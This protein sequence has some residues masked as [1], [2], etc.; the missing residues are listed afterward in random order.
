MSSSSEE[1]IQSDD[2]ES[3]IDDEIES[4][5]EENGTSCEEQENRPE[6]VDVAELM[7]NLQPYL[8]EPEKEGKPS[9]SEEEDDESDVGDEN[10]DGGEPQLRA[11][12]KEWCKCGQ[13]KH[14]IRE[15]DCLCCQEVAAISENKFEDNLCITRSSEFKVLCVEKSVLKNV[16]VALHE[17]R[18]DP[19]ENGNEI[20]ITGHFVSL[21]INNLFGGFMTGLGKEI[22]GLY[23]S[24]L[25]GQ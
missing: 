24:V 25:Y 21:L 1:Y 2:I 18:G 13:C 12:H 14:E 6:E 23:H 7:G 15:I 3:Y 19:L 20:A 16:L 9:S 4:H 11:G 5:D 10:D 8:Y 22:D 17:T